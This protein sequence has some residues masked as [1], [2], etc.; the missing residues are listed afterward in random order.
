MLRFPPLRSCKPFR[1]L[2]KSQKTMK[3]ESW[4]IL[5]P[6]RDEYEN[7]EFFEDYYERKKCKVKYF[8]IPRNVFEQSLWAHHDKVES[9]VNYGCLNYENA[10]FE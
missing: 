6:L 10:E 7:I 1:L 5:E 2:L 4:N 8:H 9:I 3:S